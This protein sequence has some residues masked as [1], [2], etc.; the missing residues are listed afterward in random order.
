MSEILAPVSGTAV[1]LSA[2]DDPVFSQGMVGPGAAVEPNFEPEVAAVR[3]PQGGEVPKDVTSEAVSPI[4]GTI[5]KLHPHAFVVAGTHGHGVLVHL[6]IDTVDLKGEGFELLVREGETVTA[7]QAIVRWSPA[8]VRASGRS[9]VCPVIALDADPS[10]VTDLASGEI[11]TG[12]AL[13]TW[14]DAT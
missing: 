14:S 1:D 11:N 6:G 4:G 12:E 3:E 8:A 9:A 7:G 2:V 13:F 10:V 5:V